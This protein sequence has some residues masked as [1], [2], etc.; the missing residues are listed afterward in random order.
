MALLQSAFAGSGQQIAVDERIVGRHGGSSL[1]LQR[2]ECSRVHLLG[3][4][5]AIYRVLS[6]G[7]PVKTVDKRRDRLLEPG[8]IVDFKRE[9]PRRHRQQRAVDGE[10]AASLPS[11]AAKSSSRSMPVRDSKSFSSSVKRPFGFRCR[12]NQFFHK[13]S[14]I[15]EMNEV[16][17]LAS[18]DTKS[19]EPI[20]PGAASQEAMPWREPANE[21]A[22]RVSVLP[23]I[24]R[25]FEHRILH[26][27]HARRNP[28]TGII[29]GF[30]N[31][32]FHVDCKQIAGSGAVRFLNALEKWAT[33]KSARTRILNDFRDSL[34]FH[35]IG[36]GHEQ[37][38]AQGHQQLPI[39]GRRGPIAND[40]ETPV[41]GMFR[42]R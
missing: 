36:G 17:K 4:S 31:N 14:R 13:A 23:S 42:S 40:V 15:P 33:Y 21:S 35:G 26:V 28:P 12:A 18:G 38:V 24:S 29:Y 6:G 5:N 34:Q 30:R 10:C 20:A 7:W 2:I 32:L 41:E 16:A 8:R 19:S 11:G 1:T 9:L 27:V 22:A 3:F 25:L 37:V 39:G